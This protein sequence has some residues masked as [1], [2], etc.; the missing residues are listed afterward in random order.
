MQP[1]RISYEEQD[2]TRAREIRAKNK[3]V[4]TRIDLRAKN[5]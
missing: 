1:L 5:L 4:K 2:T 3:L